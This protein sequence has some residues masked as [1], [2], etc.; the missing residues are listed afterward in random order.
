[1]QS[2]K[3]DSVYAALLALAV[4]SSVVHG[5]THPEGE[6]LLQ[7]RAALTTGPGAGMRPTALASRL[8]ASMMRGSH[9]YS[10]RPEH[11]ARTEASPKE[12]VN[13]PRQSQLDLASGHARSGAWA[14]R[15]IPSSVSLL[16]QRMSSFV[17]VAKASHGARASEGL[18][19]SMVVVA[20]L[21]IVLSL[22][23]VVCILFAMRDRFPS[24]R[25]ESM[26][27]HSHVLGDAE[28]QTHLNVDSV[29]LWRPHISFP[30][31]VA[32]VPQDT[33]MGPPL[34]SARPIR[35]SEHSA[36]GEAA[37][38]TPVSTPETQSA[39][40]PSA[41]T[42]AVLASPTTNPRAPLCESLVVPAGIECALM[43][44]ASFPPGRAREVMGYGIAS[45]FDVTDATGE[46]F[47]SFSV[48]AADGATGGHTVPRVAMYSA[49][50]R[51]PS[52]PGAVLA[53]C[54][55]GADNFLICRPSGEFFATLE[56]D[57]KSAGSLGAGAQKPHRFVFRDADSRQSIFDVVRLDGAHW[58]LFVT[59]EQGSSLAE[60]SP[61]R[62]EGEDRG[63]QSLRFLIGPGS[64][65]GAMLCGL[66]CSLQILQTDDASAC[67]E[68]MP[69][70]SFSGARASQP[71]L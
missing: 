11:A 62:S 12:E 55:P 31:S 68:L 19:E 22:L 20:L 63:D 51:W 71:S 43:L 34:L 69:R 48:V 70:F 52:G 61:C 24:A 33:G 30:S 53:T 32:R 29:G 1:M 60:C 27:G 8:R 15:V 28:I 49:G 58:H 4:L 2:T 38:R 9:K 57:T 42:T 40:P 45:S 44:M 35:S 7:R 37:A 14:L 17:Q 47:V 26:S 21:C 66:I 25:P 50:Q 10:T 36:G 67:L 64:D 13:A 23:C 5:T 54:A 3:I 59:D 39:K 18:D 6:H 16:L 65:V 56:R 41:V 46:P